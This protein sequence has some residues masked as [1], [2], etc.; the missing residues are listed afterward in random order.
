MSMRIPL[1]P[2]GIEPAVPKPT[3]PRRA[4]LNLWCDLK[5]VEQEE[6]SELALKEFACVYEIFK[7]IVIFIRV[8]NCSESLN[9]TSDVNG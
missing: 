7:P 2:S 5:S 3:A 4:T 8:H 1:T 9:V 6:T